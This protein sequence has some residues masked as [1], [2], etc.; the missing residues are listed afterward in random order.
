M[1]DKRLVCGTFSRA[2]LYSKF[3]GEKRLLLLR[4]GGVSGCFH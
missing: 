2:S 1:K 3:W 4:V